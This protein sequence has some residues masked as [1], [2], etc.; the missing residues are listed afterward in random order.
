MHVSHLSLTQFR[1]Y[2]RLELELSA[3][4]HLLQGEN[5]QGKTNL[6]EAIYYLATTKSPLASLD[7]ELMRWEADQ[8]VLPHSYVSGQFVRAGRVRTIGV[9]LVKERSDNSLTDEPVFRR[10]IELDGAVRRAIDVVGQLNVV[11]FLPEDIEL[12]AGAPGA[13]RHYLDVLLCQIDA[14]YCR[15]LSRYNRVLTQRN[16]LLKQLREGTVGQAELPYWDDQLASLG[17]LVLSRRLAACAALAESATHLQQRLTGARESLALHYV[18]SA[19]EV[20]GSAM[21]ETHDADGRLAAR[22]PAEADEPA[23]KQALLAALKRNLSEDKARGVTQVG[24]HRDDVRFLINDVDA[25]IYGSRGQQRTVALALKLAEVELMTARVGEPPVLLLDD[26]V[27]ELDQRR[28]D[29]LLD[30]L[31]RA[32]QVLITTTDLHH[33][34]EAFRERALLWQVRQGEISLLP[35]RA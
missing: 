35:G 31:D 15:A 12:V 7:R 26:V 34:P 9:T 16:A 3:R 5:A 33:L 29:C 17:A 18:S 22:L 11:L 21:R 32:E 28:C 10:Q 23:Q 8:E 14:E 2:A 27:S 13:R 1:N 19:A 24:P 25:T 4:I 20:A 6:L 30:A